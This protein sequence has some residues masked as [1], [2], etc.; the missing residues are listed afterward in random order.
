MHLTLAAVGFWAC[1]HE[2]RAR[3]DSEQLPYHPEWVK[4]HDSFSPRI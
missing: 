2:D 4:L 1:T 3:L